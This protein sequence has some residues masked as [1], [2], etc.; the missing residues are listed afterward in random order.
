MALPQIC[1]PC[2][3]CVP[4]IPSQWWVTA[5]AAHVCCD[6]RS[7][8]ELLCTSWDNNTALGISSYFHKLNLTRFPHYLN[9]LLFS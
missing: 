2:V 7:T 6:R 1:S 3:F 5:L 9:P 4:R 8:P